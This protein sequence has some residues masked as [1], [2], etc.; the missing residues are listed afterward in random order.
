MTDPSSGQFQN[1]Q[2]VL[3]IH[4]LFQ[5]ISSYPIYTTFIYDLTGKLGNGDMLD[6]HYRPSHTG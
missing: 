5:V 3:C 1:N 6:V 2:T 4:V